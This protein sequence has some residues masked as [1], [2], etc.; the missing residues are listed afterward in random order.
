MPGAWRYGV[1]VTT[2]TR[3]R[4]PDRRSGASASAGIAGLGTEQRGFLLRG[5]AAGGYGG[6]PPELLPGTVPSCSEDGRAPRN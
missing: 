5:F 4:C 1:S 6:I 3:R 2:P